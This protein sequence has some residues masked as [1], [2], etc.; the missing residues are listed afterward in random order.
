[1]KMLF[2]S[3]VPLSLYFKSY[4]QSQKPPSAASKAPRHLLDFLFEELGVDQE[5]KT[6][7]DLTVASNISEAEYYLSAGTLAEAEEGDDKFVTCG[8][9]TGK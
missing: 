5:K 4:F 8:P 6:V 7:Q 2:L 1:M 9:G 3:A